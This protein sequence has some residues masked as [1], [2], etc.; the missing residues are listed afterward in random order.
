MMHLAYTS[1]AVDLMDADDL[2]QILKEARERNRRR[3]VTGML[4]YRDGTFLQVLEGKEEDVIH[5][6][7][8][9]KSDGR[10]RGLINVLQEPIEK[11][12]FED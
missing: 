2:A 7:D 8:L 12:H 9:I 10:H 1:T 3:N 4:L 5:I 11:H 6:Y